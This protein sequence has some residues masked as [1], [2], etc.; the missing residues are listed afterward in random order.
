[1]PSGIEGSLL[2][3]LSMGFLRLL[4]YLQ[5]LS[6]VVFNGKQTYYNKGQ[7]YGTC[8]SDGDVLCVVSPDVP[9]APTVRRRSTNRSAHAEAVTISTLFRCWSSHFRTRSTKRVALRTWQSRRYCTVYEKSTGST[10]L[11]P[12]TVGDQD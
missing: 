4:V 12:G 6:K 2:K 3:D 11:V 9:S 10:V 5:R 8:A 7:C 1:M